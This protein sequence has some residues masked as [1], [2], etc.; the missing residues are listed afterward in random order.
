LLDIAVDGRVVTTAHPE[1][2]RER[3]LWNARFDRRP[4]AVVEVANAEDVRRTIAV[5]REHDIQLVARSGGH[6]FGGYCVADDALVLDVS[7]LSQVEVSP[8][9][10]RVRLGAGATLL[11]IYQA[12]WPHR[13]AVAGGTCPTVGITGLT[14]AGGLGVLSRVHGLTCDSLLEGEIVTAAGEVV[15]A[16]GDE[17]A[18]L[19]WALRGGGG[20]NFGIVVSLTFRLVP[21]DMPFTHATIEFS[22]DEAAS[23]VAAWQEW[24]HDAPPEL[25]AALMIET[26]APA[27][28]PSLLIE[29]VY[30]GD[31]G[32]LDALI[33]GFPVRPSAVEKS[34]SDFVTIPSEFYCKGLRPEECHTADLFP[35]GKLP[36]TAYHAKCDVATAPWPAAGIGELLSA[37]EERQRDPLLTPADFDPHT[38]CGKLLL[39]PADGAVGSVA[40][41][42]TAFPHRDALFVAQYAMRWRKGA[43]R[44]VEAANLEWGERLWA[45]VEPYRSGSSYLAYIDTEL[46]GW[47]EAYYGANLAR[48]REVKARYDPDDFFRFDRSIPP[49]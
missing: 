34:T 11:P 4:L 47:E 16:A 7:E 44:E 26:R 10:T 14:A 15:R 49:E 39:E 35:Q 18:D 46:E 5:A 48:L 1:Y 25:W 36:H 17:N 31:P 3:L 32:R 13:R 45:A 19:F 41:N 37:M 9:A 20:G 22:W 8:D 6:S 30:A 43:S 21:V 42:A 23:V 2:E 38:D 40:P 12:L 27:L 28:G 33:A 29:A 24:A